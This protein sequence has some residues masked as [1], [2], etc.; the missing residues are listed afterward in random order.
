MSMETAAEIRTRVYKFGN[1]Q[2]DGNSGMKNLLGGKGA[3]LAEMSALNIPV[4]PGFYNY[5]R[6]LYG[7]QF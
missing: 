3:N 4:P 7:I 2:A 5:H 6:S 1:N